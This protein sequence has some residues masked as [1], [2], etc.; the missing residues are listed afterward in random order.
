MED[1]DIDAERINEEVDSYEVWANEAIGVSINKLEK[2]IYRSIILSIGAIVTALIVSLLTWLFVT[3]SIYN[4]IKIVLK[5]LKEISENSGDLTQQIHFTSKDEIGDLARNFNLMQDSLR[6]II[7]EVIN[8]SKGIGKILAETN[9]DITQLSFVIDK[10]NH[11]TEELSAG[12]EETAASTDN[13]NVSINEMKNIANKLSQKAK[14]EG[15][16]AKEISLRAG[17]TEKRAQESQSKSY[18]LYKNARENMNATTERSKDLEQI[19]VLANTILQISAQTN[20]LALNASIEAAR[21]G[22][23]GRG[24]AVVAEEI[25]KLAEESEGA[26]SEIQRVTDIIRGVVESLTNDSQEILGFIE[27]NVMEDYKT[28]AQT[29]QQYNE[30]AMYYDKKSMELNET[31]IQLVSSIQNIGHSMGHI[32]MAVGE[33]AKGSQDIAA[34]TNVIVQGSL[35]IKENESKIET[36]TKELLEI[37]ST[38]EI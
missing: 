6:G 35:K 34:Q 27:N 20:L 28:L 23:H 18:E 10:V 9:Q 38:F 3:K 31:S 32:S 21:A 8:S 4:P 7:G 25:R 17:I 19:T 1:F 2:M 29:S 5:K 30:D 36:S 37:L 15:Q 12:M 16:A 14:E 24:F 11:T 13:I 22:E 33:G 26:V